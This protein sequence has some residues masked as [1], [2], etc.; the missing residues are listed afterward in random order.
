MAKV[1]GIAASLDGR[2]K[3][4]VRAHGIEINDL[5]GRTLAEGVLRYWHHGMGPSPIELKG[6][7]LFDQNVRPTSDADITSICSYLPH[8]IHRGLIIIR[9]LLQ[10]E[11]MDIEQLS[12]RAQRIDVGHGDPVER[13][14]IRGSVG[15]VRALTRLDIAL[16]R[17]PVAFSRSIEMMEIPSL[18]P[19]LPA[20]NIACQPLEAAFAEKLLAVICQPGT[21]MRVKH[22]ADIA[23]E[24]L[25][26]GVE[27]HQ[28]AVELDRV[29]HHRRIDISALPDVLDIADYERLRSNWSKF[30]RPGMMPMSFDEAIEAAD[31]IWQDV[32]AA[33]SMRPPAYTSERWFGGVR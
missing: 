26:D 18:A 2:L 30:T 15:G 8:E 4:T 9:S 33:T 25:W 23:A 6:G 27:A 14:T 7:L 22:L 28:V 13:W 24:R 12:D 5:A 31:G 17:G 19:R 10:S 21:D 29:C 11:G 3:A 20:L 1:S 32:Q 16:G